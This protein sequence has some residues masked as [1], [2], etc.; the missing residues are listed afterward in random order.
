MKLFSRGCDFWQLP[1]AA[2]AEG[3]PPSERLDLEAHAAVCPECADALRNARA[4][5]VAVRGAFSTLRQRRALLAPGRVRLAVGPR[6][7]RPVERQTWLRV[8]AFFG[9]LAEVSVMLGVTLFVVGGSFEEPR[10][11]PQEP[12][13]VIQEYF[14]SRPTDDDVIEY[15]RW[16]QLRGKAPAATRDVVRLPAGGL[17]D[18]EPAEIVTSRTATPR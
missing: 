3:L 17:Y 4:V 18:V 2:A 16:L 5:D 13:S 15:F 12:Q 9:R 7:P 14:R 11:V 1:Y 8:P 10:A 6:G